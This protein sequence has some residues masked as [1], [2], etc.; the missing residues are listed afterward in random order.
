MDLRS[1]SPYWLLKNGLMT[2]YPSLSSDHRTDIAIMGAGIS[3]ALVAW[4]LCRAGF[5]VTVVDK[6]HVG[7]GSTAASTAL[8]QYEIDT[9]LYRLISIAG[10]RQAIRSY[11]LCAE[12]A[13]PRIA[14]FQEIDASGS[15][16][17]IIVNNAVITA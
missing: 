11:Q 3:G 7:M 1:H 8:L 10:E 13:A 4:H 9:P 14:S 17:K 16:L 6:R 15:T 12:N 2:N 5:D